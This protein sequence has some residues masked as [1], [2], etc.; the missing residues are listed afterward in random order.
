MFS[1]LLADDNALECQITSDHLRGAGYR[2][3]SV[4]DGLSALDQLRQ[5]P[6]DLL[7]A[8]VLMPRLDGFEL[9]RRC[10]EEA[11]L[12]GLPIIL[13]SG[14]YTEVNERQLGLGFGANRYLLKPVDP[15]LLQ[16]LLARTCG[17]P[18]T[19]STRPVTMRQPR[20]CCRPCP[21]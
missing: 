8:D 18:P 15:D 11:A 16:P 12:R 1:L 9:C 2:V 5:Q 17:R 13:C 7:I 21:V 3:T 4:T 6:F 14:S 10:R 19:A 20:L